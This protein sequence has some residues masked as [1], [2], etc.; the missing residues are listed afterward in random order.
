M[1]D[2]AGT[3]CLAAKLMKDEGQKCQGSGN[4]AVLSGPAYERIEKSP[5]VE[6]V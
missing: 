3:I 1:I 6:S 5:I 4:H 2:T